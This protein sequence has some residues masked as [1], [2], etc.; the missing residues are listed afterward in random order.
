MPARRAL[1]SNATN[2]DPG[3]RSLPA[4]IEAP[5]P[6]DRLAA[7]TTIVD[8]TSRYAMCL[9]NRD[10]EGLARLFTD[11]V[12]IDL[13][14]VNGSAPVTLAVHEYLA[15]MARNLGGFKATQ[16]AFSNH[17]VSFDDE[18]PDEVAHCLFDGLAHHVLPGAD[19]PDL[20]VMGVRYT[21]VVVCRVHRQGWRIGALRIERLWASRAW[22]RLRRP[23]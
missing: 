12:A 20:L 22:H 16:H 23:A 15:L 5:L 11:P 19:G 8:L 21:A 7:R 1:P 3:A 13:S 10:Y 18:R 2:A 4:R 6:A 14:S 9:D 17:L